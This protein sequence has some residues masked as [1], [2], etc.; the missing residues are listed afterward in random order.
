MY[1]SLENNVPYIRIE[2]KEYLR[3]K[4]IDIVSSKDVEEVVSFVHP[5]YGKD[6]YQRIYFSEK[7]DYMLERLIN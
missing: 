1:S 7:L 2:R 4:I 3:L 6:V 5:I